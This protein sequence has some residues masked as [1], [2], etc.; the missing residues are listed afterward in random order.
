ME[1]APTP[2]VQLLQDAFGPS[3]KLAE[4]CWIAW[5]LSENQTDFGPAIETAV[6]SGAQKDLVRR[7]REEHPLN[8]EHRL[9]HDH[10]VLNFFTEVEAFAWSAEIAGLPRPRFITTQGS[11]DLLA[12]DC[13]IEAKTINKSDVARNYDEHVIRPAL[14]AGRMVVSQAVAL[15]PPLP[16]LIAK[17]QAGL[18]DGTRKWDRQG[19]SGQLVMFYEWVNIDF[20]VSKRDAERSV[21]DW[22]RRQERAT[23]VRIVIAWNYRWQT[24]LFPES[25]SS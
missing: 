8:R 20:G 5:A 3:P 1:T 19:R 24:P 13:W 7:L 4:S 9:R 2:L 17:F 25:P 23:G 14:E 10:G 22:A 21:L 18:E 15:A 11:P 12:G 16:G 6:R